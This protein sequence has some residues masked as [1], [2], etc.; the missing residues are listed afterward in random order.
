MELGFET[1]GNAVLVCH[2]RSPV[3]VTDPWIDGGAYFGSWGRSHAI[4]ADVMAS[5]K[6]CPYVWIS[7]G[8]PDHFSP[9]SLQ[10]L[11]HK[12]ILLPDHIGGLIRNGLIGRGFDVTVLKD[13]RWVKLSDRIR[14]LSI[15]DYNQDGVLLV[16]IDGRLIVNMNDAGDH[17]WGSFVKKVIRRY[18]VSF[19]LH[20]A[21]FG[22]SD[23]IN[24]YRDD[25]TFVVPRAAKAHPVGRSMSN[26]ADQW[27]TRFTIPFSSMHVYQRADS[28]W[29][30]KYT[31]RLSDYEVGWN[32][33]K[34]ELLPAFIRYDAARDSVEQIN[35]EPVATDPIDP[36]KFGDNWAEPIEPEDKPKISAYFKAI[37]HLD[38][39][40][41]FI[42]V[43]IGGI[44]HLI[45]LKSKSFVRGLTFEAPRT[46]FM[47]S[48]DYGIFDDLLIGNFMKVTVNGKLSARPLYPDFTPYVTKYADNGMAR[49]KP[50]LNQYFA[51]YRAKY[52]LGYLRHR[53]D[54]KVVQ[55]VRH[56]IEEDGALY[57]AGAR[58]YHWLKSLGTASRSEPVMVAPERSPASH[59]ISQ[60]PRV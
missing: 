1:I 6:S 47:T 10:L 35:P 49:T 57:R 20:L 27:G 9:R 8:H 12:K 37:L 11:G 60:E 25:G 21:G 14:I 13:C 31:T 50:E 36:E 23:M 33:K 30:A 52:P 51:E 58:S 5:I 34:A 3:L 39:A 18:D 55:K 17:G 56:S 22:D 16:D 4:P 41:D 19:M 40:F 24:L 15:A 54:A 43:R 26:W 48:I 29:A 32:A 42:R 38:Q 44:E 7:H 46:S 45:E 53:I 59:D 28:I 2:D